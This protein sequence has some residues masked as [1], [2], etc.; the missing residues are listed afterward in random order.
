MSTDT[1]TEQPTLFDN[2]YDFLL[3]R[4]FVDNATG[5]RMRVRITVT[6][7]P[8]EPAE[9]EAPAPPPPTP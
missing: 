1:T 6:A 9:P 4:V 5:A 7:E 8:V 2:P 3:P